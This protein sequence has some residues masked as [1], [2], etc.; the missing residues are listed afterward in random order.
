MDTQPQNEYGLVDSLFVSRK[1][2]SESI[3]VGGLTEDK[4]RWV[5]VLAQRAAQMFWF[6]LMRYLFPEKFQMMAALFATAPM[7]DP[8]LPTVTTHITVDDLENGHFLVT[9]YFGDQTW[10]LRISEYEA[11]RLWVALDIALYPVGWQGKKDKGETSPEQ[12]NDT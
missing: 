11:R 4:S 6:H 9:G 8:A 1:A 2:N 7:R 10:T 3:I 5:R 12:D